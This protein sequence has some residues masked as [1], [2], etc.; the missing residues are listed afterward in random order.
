MRNKQAI[1]GI[2][3]A[4][5]ILVG[6]AGAFMLNKNKTATQPN[7]TTSATNTTNTSSN[8]AMSGSIQDIFRSTENRKCDFNVA[9]KSGGETQGTIYTSNNKT[10]GELTTTS[11]GKSSKM[12]LIR[13]GETFYMWGDSLPTGVKLTMSVDE[14]GSK[15]SGNASYGN[16]DPN[17]KVDFKCGSWTVDSGKFTLPANVKFMDTGSMMINSTTTPAKSSNTTGASSQCS[18]CNSLT[19]EAKTSCLTSLN[20]K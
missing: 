14:M 19:G 4:V 17:Q 9:G 6:A 13:N 18:I 10:Y 1:I 16:F 8:S 20:C 15:M 3:I 7:S 11:N 5:I 2:V 12:Y